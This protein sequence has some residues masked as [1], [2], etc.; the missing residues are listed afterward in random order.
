MRGVGILQTKGDG[1]K[2]KELI[3]SLYHAEVWLYWD[4]EAKE[5]KRDFSRRLGENDIDFTFDGMMA[6]V[7][8]LELRNK[9][10]KLNR[11]IY[12]M[13]FSKV[14]RVDKLYALVHECDH[15]VNRIFLHRGITVTFMDCEEHHA[16]YLEAWF[17]RVWR[18][19]G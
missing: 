13:W 7:S 5:V 4:C 17:K 8:S 14:N 19:I 18:L 1:L 2:R 9:E 6:G 12:V 16:Y 10:G 15:L 11:M 3:D